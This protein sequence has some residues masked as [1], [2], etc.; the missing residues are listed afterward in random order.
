MKVDAPPRKSANLAAA[1]RIT[2]TNTGPRLLQNIVVTDVL[3]QGK[4]DRV[5]SGGQKLPGPRRAVDRSVARAANSRGCSISVVSK[6]D[7]GLVRHKVSAVYRGLTVPAE[8]AD[9]VRGGRR[10]R[11]YDFRGSTPTVE[12]N[13]EVIYDLTV[14]NSGSAAATNIRPTIELP[15]ELTLVKAEPEN[16]VDGGKVAFDPIADIAADGRATFRVTAKAMKPS[17]GARGD[18]GVGRR[19][20]PD[21]PGEAAG[22]DGDR[23]QPAGPAGSRSGRQA[24]AAGARG[25]AGSL[26]RQRL[27]A[28]RLTHHLPPVVRLRAE[29]AELGGRHFMRRS[30]PAS[31]AT[32]MSVAAFAGRADQPRTPRTVTAQM[33][34]E[35]SQRRVMPFPPWIPIPGR[36][37]L[38][39]REW[40]G[41][42]NFGA[43]YRR[44]MPGGHRLS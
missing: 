20:V 42:S 17:L 22:N 15:P 5:A 24:A 2:L 31:S 13:G 32:W 3:D 16:K 28:N 33:E 25:T 8:A 40:V 27:M 21:R 19:P 14:R 29:V 36:H 7:G 38:R 9:R 23:R 10:A 26:S 43:K 35:T 30:P 1:A 18:G 4:V 37:V 6:S 44:P 41:R 34:A 39:R 11:R 12:V